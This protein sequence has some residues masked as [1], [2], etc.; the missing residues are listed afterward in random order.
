MLIAG[1]GDVAAE[2]PISRGTGGNGD[3]GQ[4][5]ASPAPKGPLYPRLQANIFSRIE[6]TEQAAAALARYGVILT[7]GL[8][9]RGASGGY[10]LGVRQGLG[11]FAGVTYDLGSAQSAQVQY[12]R[13]KQINP[14]LKV[15][16]HRGLAFIEAAW[17]DYGP[18][19]PQRWSVDR[20]SPRWLA[21]T[22]LAKL[23]QAVTDAI[24]IELQFSPAVV[25]GWLT[26]GAKQGPAS[27]EE[28]VWRPKN[29]FEWEY[30]CFFDNDAGAGRG[31]LEIMAVRHFDKDSGV[32]EVA[33]RMVDGEPRRAIFGRPQHY[34]A[35]S[36]AGL[37]ASSAATFG[38]LAFLA[39]RMCRKGMAGGC[40]QTVTDDG[41]DWIGA[42][43]EYVAQ[44][45][46]PSR[47]PAEG[48]DATWLVDGVIADADDMSWRTW[49]FSHAD[50][51]KYQLDQDLDGKID[52]VDDASAALPLA[53]ADYAERVAAAAT[54]AGRPFALILNGHLDLPQPTLDG[55][56]FEDF[57]AGFQEGYNQAVAQYRALF[58]PGMLREGPSYVV[59]SERNREHLDVHDFAAHRHILALTLTL[60][61]G[62]YGHDGAHATRIGAIWPVHKDQAEDWFDELSVDPEGYA[63]DHPSHTGDGR[64]SHLGWLGH[65]LG[66]AREVAGEQGSVWRR[67]FE[68]GVSFYTQAGVV[69]DLDPP[70]QRICG[71][72]PGNDGSVV[73]RLELGPLAVDADP[74]KGFGVVLRRDGS[75]GPCD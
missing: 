36:R 62:Y 31:E 6:P 19:S 54:V 46:L 5:A 43:T 41:V 45:L 39:N 63:A 66:A 11:S 27:N 10:D 67:D 8:F 4:G 29:Q 44:M 69:L 51:K 58:E 30:L 61:D 26:A 12:G 23:Q 34:S 18:T 65:A 70:L 35:G 52:A 56:R 7:G 64:S 3:G 38:S 57:N 28:P 75:T 59:V 74:A 24:T 33:A 72:D 40:A 25:K 20:L 71:M 32:V 55:R 22:P 47:Y 17:F 16:T 48:P 49:G 9:S 14:E 13:A 21:Y 50:P 53:Y 1:C 60:G 37:L 42:A 2:I 68:H 73:S 15:F